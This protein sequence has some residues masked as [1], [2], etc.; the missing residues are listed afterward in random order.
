MRIFFVNFF[1]F[2]LFFF[3]DEMKLIISSDSPFDASKYKI[4][5][6]SHLNINF[7]NISTLL[8]HIIMQPLLLLLQ[9]ELRKTEYTSC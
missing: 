7:I 8:Q 1:R 9:I 2:F 5:I 6:I 3:L 4:R